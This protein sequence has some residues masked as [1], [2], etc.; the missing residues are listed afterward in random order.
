[1]EPL[2]A[3]SL[4]SSVV[5]LV[6]F[7]IKV[8]TNSR[9]IYKSAEGA[10]NA[11]SFLSNATGNL[12]ELSATLL[13]ELGNNYLINKKTNWLRAKFEKEDVDDREQKA[14]KVVDEKVQKAKKAA[15]KQLADL[16]RQSRKVAAALQSK[17]DSLKRTPNGGKWDALQTSFRIIFEQGEIDTLVA[18]LNSIQKQIDTALLISLRC[19]MEPVEST[20]SKPMSRQKKELLGS[21]HDQSHQALEE[22]RMTEFSHTFHSAVDM[23]I[24]ERFCEMMLA[25]LFFADMPERYEAIPKAHRDTFEWMLTED[26]AMASTNTWDDFPKWLSNTSGSNLYWIAGK[27][28]SGKSTLMRYL[29]DH[30]TTAKF[31]TWNG[32]DPVVKAGFFFWNSGTVMQMSRMGLLQTLLHGALRADKEAL[33]QIF[34]HRWLQYV[35]FAGG[36]HPLSWSELR[37]AFEKLIA[38]PRGRKRYFFMIDGLDEFDGDHKE[39]VDLVTSA[40]AK[41]HVKVC[42]ASRPWLVFAD[43][44]EHRPKLFLEQLTERDIRKYVGDAFQGNRHYKRLIEL[45]PDRAA[46]LQTEIT[47]R[48][49]GVFLWVRLVVQS[50]LDGLSDGD[51]MSNLFARFESL[52]REL[53]A[54]YDRLLWSLDE[55]YFKDACQLIRL[56]MSVERPLLLELWFADDDDCTSTMGLHPRFSS[57]IEVKNRMETMHRRILARCKCFLEIE[58]FC[59]STM[60]GY[61]LSKKSQVRFFHRTARDFLQSPEMRETIL[62]GTGHDLF[63]TERRWAN[64]YMGI[65]KTVHQSE[66]NTDKYFIMCIEYALRVEKRTGITPTSYLDEVGRA[67]TRIS[68]GYHQLSIIEDFGGASFRKHLPFRSF[69]DFAVWC[70]LVGYV[71][72]SADS[73][74]KDT[75]LHAA[76]FKNGVLSNG[77]VH[78]LIT[79]HAP[80]LYKAMTSDR[81]LLKTVLSDALGARRKEARRTKWKVARNRWFT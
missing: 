21:L 4:A 48:A 16:A 73:V 26:P 77:R 45:E 76:P 2:S 27:P 54:L 66:N 41:P 65:I 12:S 44:F 53:E 55:A 20:G 9:E 46:S 69:M 42:V 67:A 17:L 37:E 61:W 23:D 13:D 30:I 3:L 29:Y 1:M 10:S 33:L 31:S 51:R 38:E 7:S 64:A 63:D 52:P 79:S 68:E 43:R 24:E 50:L 18:E 75:L 6:D 81:A 60:P 49:A 15:D 62:D 25:R 56:V 19:V 74:S 5:Q 28:G 39:L 59:D 8:V 40:A 14:E 22:F 78:D 35:A 72:A 58:D 47:T 32:D 57:P 36:R 34:N 80:T 70:N 71:K 11:H